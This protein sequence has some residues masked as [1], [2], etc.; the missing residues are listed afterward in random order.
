MITMPWQSRG[1]FGGRGGGGG[2][3]QSSNWKRNKVQKDC[4]I[5]TTEIKANLSSGQVPPCY[6]YLVTLQVFLM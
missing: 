3:Q 4:A 2:G 1:F 6:F 5:I